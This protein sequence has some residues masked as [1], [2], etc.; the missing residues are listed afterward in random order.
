MERIWIAGCAGSGKT[1]LANLIAEKLRIP[2]Y[3]RDY[4]TWNKNFNKARTEDEQIIITR[5]ITKNDKWIFDGARFTA[6]K[7]DGRL[8]RCDTI[9]HLSFNRFLCL[10][11][12]I[13]RG[14][15]KAKL[16]SISEIDKQPFHFELFR[17][18]L[19][20]YPKKHRQRD[21]IFDLA[22]NKGINVI[23]LKNQNEVDGF[24]MGLDSKNEKQE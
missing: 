8:E 24:I 15:R 12:A 1:T 9:I 6:S 2:I 10:Y 5:D 19:F 13:K 3:H 11:R 14:Y 17:Y 23:I 7:I 16:K 4:I 18:I 22:R 20:D 21:E